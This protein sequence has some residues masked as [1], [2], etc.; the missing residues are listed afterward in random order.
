M[1][2]VSLPC[3]S[4][5]YVASSPP[6]HYTLTPVIPSNL[7]PL[8]ACV[9]ESVSA[10]RPLSMYTVEPSL[11]SCLLPPS[12]ARQ[13]RTASGTSVCLHRNVVNSRL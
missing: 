9:Y 2:I 10:V 4:F 1:T 13:R 5:P 8:S 3:V 6:A 7:E 11:G 12:S